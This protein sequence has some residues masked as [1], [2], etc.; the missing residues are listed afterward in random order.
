M[1]TDRIAYYLVTDVNMAA[2]LQRR[3]RVLYT[4]IAKYLGIVAQKQFRGVPVPMDDGLV[5]WGESILI[6]TIHTTA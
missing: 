4:R 2:K 5:Q 1:H 3:S 6:H